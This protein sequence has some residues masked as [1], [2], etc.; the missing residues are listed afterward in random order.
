MA[1][2]NP[3]DVGWPLLGICVES[4]SFRIK[5][6]LVCVCVCVCVCVSF[7]V[8]SDSL[9]PHGLLPTRLLHPWNFPGKSTGLGC[10]FL[11]W[12]RT[13]ETQYRNSAEREAGKVKLWSYP[14]P[15]LCCYKSSRS[16]PT[17]RLSTGAAR[18]TTW[19]LHMLNTDRGLLVLSLAPA[20]VLKLL[21]EHDPY[22]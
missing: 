13:L 15:G 3:A 12:K 1:G 18:H 7:L 9:W 21:K 8:V 6:N 16:P 22:T 4:L 5:K 2:Q 19:T 10:H 20:C 11:L 17:G 14:F